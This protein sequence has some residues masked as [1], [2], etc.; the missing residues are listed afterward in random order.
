MDLYPTALMSTQ[1]TLNKF[2]AKSDDA[3][4]SNDNL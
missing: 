3:D 2:L 1:S 4:N